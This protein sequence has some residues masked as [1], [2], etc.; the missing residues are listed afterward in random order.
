MECARPPIHGEQAVVVHILEIEIG[1]PNVQ[2]CF[3]QTL[4][5]C[6]RALTF[7]MPRKED[8][9]LSWRFRFPALVVTAGGAALASVAAWLPASVG[10]WLSRALPFPFPS[11]F[12]AAA[13]PGF[14]W[15]SRALPFPLPL[16]A[17]AGPGLPTL[18]RA[19]ALPTAPAPVNEGDTAGGEVDSGDPVD[20]AA[21][22]GQGNVAATRGGG[23]VWRLDA[24]A[25]AG[26]DGLGVDLE[27]A[28][29]AAFVAAAAAAPS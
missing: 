5:H 19:A 16:G 18:A 12:G 13:G 2:P 9:G 6:G 21:P 17:A 14:P 23:V 8:P 1:F 24:E 3:R 27:A 22:A 26:V 29:A 4:H 25:A 11:P 28:V 10:A 7:W 15:L 20:G